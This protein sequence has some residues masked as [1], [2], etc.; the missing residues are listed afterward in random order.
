MMRVSHAAIQSLM[1]WHLDL[2]DPLNP[3][4]SYLSW[5]DHW[6]FSCR[7]D[8]LFWHAHSTFVMLRHSL[9]LCVL[10]R[11]LGGER[12]AR[13]AVLLL[14]RTVCCDNT[15]HSQIEIAYLVEVSRELEVEKA[16]FSCIEIWKVAAGAQVM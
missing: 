10:L 8:Q 1:V 5:L 11:S 4:L 6:Q 12:Q 7:S 2:C 16:Q 3:L 15:L 14:S 13:S 9:L